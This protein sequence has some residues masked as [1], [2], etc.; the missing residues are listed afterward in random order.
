MITAG[1]GIVMALTLRPTDGGLA[2]RPVAPTVAPEVVTEPA[3][4][5]DVATLLTRLN[6][7]RRTHG[8]AAL[9]LDPRLCAIAQRHGLDMVSRQYFA[10]ISPEGVSP[11]GRMSQAHYRFGYAGENLALDRDS[12]A[13]H[14]SLLAS[15]EHRENMVEPHYVHVGIAT[16]ASASGEIVVEDFS[17]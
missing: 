2:A 14:R 15:P 5:R 3:P 17:D 12:E 1:F 11:F 16:V 13:I 4:T 8:L 10:H 9:V 7:V 6:D